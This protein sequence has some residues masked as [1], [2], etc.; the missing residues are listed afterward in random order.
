MIILQ[1]RGK[2]NASSV[3]AAAASSEC[4]PLLGWLLLQMQPAMRTS[5]GRSLT[6]R[7]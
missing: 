6:A 3:N 2:A 5:A 4:L 7:L 1:M